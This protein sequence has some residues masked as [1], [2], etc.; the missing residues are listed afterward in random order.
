[1]FLFYRLTFR[2]YSIFEVIV[3]QF[4]VSLNERPDV[5]NSE[6]NPELLNFYVYKN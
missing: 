3:I 2:I 6:I 5:C 4:D 1:M